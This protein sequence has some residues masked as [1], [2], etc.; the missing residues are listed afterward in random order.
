VAEFQEY[1]R[2]RSVKKV[3]LTPT[4]PPMSVPIGVDQSTGITIGHGPRSDSHAVGYLEDFTWHATLSGAPQGGI[5]SLVMSNIY[6]DR[7]DRFV[8]QQL[9]PEY[10]R[11]ERRRKNPEYH[12]IWRGIERARRHGD[13]RMERDLVQVLRRMPSQDPDDAGYRRLRYVRYCDD[14]LL[15]FAGPRHEAEQIREKLRAFLRDELALELSEPKTLIT[16]AVSQAAHFLGPRS[17]PSTPTRRSPTVVGWSTQPSAC[18]CPRPPSG[19]GAPG[20]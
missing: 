11:G 15:G 19:S 5:A 2:A 20:I 12:R 14:F 3:A 18:S 4:A 8:E 9:I 6:L 10:E 17:G 7:L 16:H 13:R 1:Y